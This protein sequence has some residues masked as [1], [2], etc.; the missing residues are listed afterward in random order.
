MKKDGTGKGFGHIQFLSLAECEKFKAAAL[1]K[2][3]K[4]GDVDIEFNVF[5][6]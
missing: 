1:N 5:K 3:V 2:E 6:K 4:F